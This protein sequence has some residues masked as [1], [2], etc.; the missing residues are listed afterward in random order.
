MAQA[1]FT[2]AMASNQFFAK[3]VRIQ[4]ERAHAVASGGLYLFVRHPGYGA[5]IVTMLAVSLLLGWL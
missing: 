3:T 4:E 1:V 5:N 2:W